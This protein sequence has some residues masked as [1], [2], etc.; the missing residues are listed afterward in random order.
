MSGLQ[1]LVST[2]GVDQTT[3]GT[4]NKVTPHA[5][6]STTSTYLPIKQDG[7]TN[8][9]QVIDYAHH[10]IHGG[11]HYTAMHGVADIGAA[12]TP[13]DA[14]T[15][16]FTTSNTAKWCHMVASFEAVGGALVT[17]REN[18]TGGASPTGAV[19]CFNNNRN[20]ANTS[21]VTDIGATAGQMSYDATLDTGGTLILSEYISGASTNQ[22]KAGGS[23]EG[24]ARYEWI[25][26]QG[27]RYQFAI[28]STANVAASI[29][30]H[31]YE[32]TDV[33]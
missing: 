4:T 26:K 20:S 5:Y 9:I 33:S 21:L 31:W 30:L 23:A 27:N 17:I 25:L 16:T 14:I 29:I 32:H 6:N 2:V 12:T 10:E 13:D 15:L 28:Y 22:N 19:T 7:T 8:A 1:K 11:S 24:G 3:D 18:G